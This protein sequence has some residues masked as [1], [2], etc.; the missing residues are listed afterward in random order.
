MVMEIS[1]APS[2]GLLRLKLNR[3]QIRVT[4]DEAEADR[5]ASELPKVVTRFPP[6]R[7]PDSITEYLRT[8]GKS[9]IW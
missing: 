5:L 3:I 1:T 8:I 9:K 2:L 7:L 6:D 4:K